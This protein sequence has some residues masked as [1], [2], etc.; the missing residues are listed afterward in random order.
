MDEWGK[1]LIL[2]LGLALGLVIHSR[3]YRPDR[4][5]RI[6]AQ[7]DLAPRLGHTV[8]TGIKPTVAGGPSTV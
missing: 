3:G 4:C 7:T 8:V 6:Q 1:L 2:G 5:K